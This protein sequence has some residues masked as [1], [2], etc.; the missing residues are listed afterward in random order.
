MRTNFKFSISCAVAFLAGWLV[1]CD[2]TVI[3]AN[4]CAAECEE[5]HPDGLRIMNDLVGGGCACQTCS[6]ECAQSVCS[7]KEAPSN[8]CLP[9][10]QEGLSGRCSHNEGFFEVGCLGN[11]DCSDLVA[12]ITACK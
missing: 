10:M 11:Q 2:N 12:C 8:A 7:S 5:Q 6:P 1:A 3:L 4:S 9:C